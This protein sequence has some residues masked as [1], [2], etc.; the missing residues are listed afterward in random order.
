MRVCAANLVL[1]YKYIPG[2]HSFAFYMLIYTRVYSRGSFWN[3]TNNNPTQC[4][5]ILYTRKIAQSFHNSSFTHFHVSARTS[6]VHTHTYI[7]F[8]LPFHRA[9]LLTDERALRKASLS[10]TQLSSR[11]CVSIY[12]DDDDDEVRD[13]FDPIRNRELE[14]CSKKKKKK[15]ACD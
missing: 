4:I 11:K 15:I 10:R 13:G 7:S 14:R 6:R 5:P 8:N 2:I 1:I 3:L 9:L 12:R